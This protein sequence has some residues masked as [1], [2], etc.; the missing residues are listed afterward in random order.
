MI[1]VTNLGSFP[2]RL[3]RTSP[4]EILHSDGKSTLQTYDLPMLPRSDIYFRVS[5]KSRLVIR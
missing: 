4:K 5:K 3:R 2:P 1:F